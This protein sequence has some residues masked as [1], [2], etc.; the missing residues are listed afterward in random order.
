MLLTRGNR[1][2]I[3][4][5]WVARSTSHLTS[6]SAE[7]PSRTLA[8]T[9]GN[10]VQIQWTWLSSWGHVLPPLTQCRGDLQDT[11]SAWASVCW[12]CL[13]LLSLIV[14]AALVTSASGLRRLVSNRQ[15]RP[16]TSHV[17]L[18]QGRGLAQIPAFPLTSCWFRSLR[19]LSSR[20]TLCTS[21]RSGLWVRGRPRGGGRA[22]SNRGVVV[23]GIYPAAW[24]LSQVC[25]GPQTIS[26][27]GFLSAL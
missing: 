23:G 9:R 14:R 18:C 16:F 20:P 8:W 5:T 3:Q 10:R 4:W 12:F 1:V 25:C 24:G 15:L 2:Q 17:S 22:A 21:V 27:L 11:C 26:G 19:K 6:H 13:R 7:V